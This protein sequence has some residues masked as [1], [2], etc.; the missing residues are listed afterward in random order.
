[1]RTPVEPLPV[2]V[3]LLEPDL[4]YVV[5]DDEDARDALRQLLESQGAR[6]VCFS[7]EL[8]LYSAVARRP[9]TAILLDVVLQWV[10]G[11]RLCEGLKQHP[12]TRGTRVVVM[13]G[14]NRPHVRERALRAGAEAFLPKP[15]RAEHLLQVL[16]HGQ[17]AKGSSLR[18]DTPVPPA[19]SERYA[20][21]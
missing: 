15:L 3:P 9:P 10:D 21:L 1:V 14:L 6:V 19:E 16:V 18:T 2:G 17:E 13:S 8:A 20:S 11:L 4:Y 5:D 12:L 7:D